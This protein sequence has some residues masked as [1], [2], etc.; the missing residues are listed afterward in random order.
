[1]CCRKRPA[2]AKQGD[3]PDGLL[4]LAQIANASPRVPK[5]AQG[6]KVDLIV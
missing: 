1:M 4:R 6:D 5:K 3:K 2:S